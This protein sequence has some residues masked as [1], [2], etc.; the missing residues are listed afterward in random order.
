MPRRMPSCASGRQ[1]RLRVVL[2]HQR[3]VVEDVLAARSSISRMPSSTITASSQANAGIVGAAVGN[4]RGDQVA[5]AVLVLQAFAAER[6]AAGGGA[7]Q[8]AARSAGRPRPRSGRRRAGSRTSSS[9]CRT[10]AS[11]GRARCSASPPRSTT[12]SAPASVMPSSRIWPSL[13]FAVVEHRAA[14][15]RA[16]RAGRPASRCRSAGRGSPCR[17]C[18]PRRR[19][20][21]RCAG[22]ASGP[23]SRLPSRRTTAIVVD[24]SLPSAS[25][26][27]VRRRR[28]AA[29]TASAGRRCAAR[30]REPPSAARRSRR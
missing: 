23:C 26:A 6:R 19:R 28:R 3:H 12:T 18:A 9:R 22:R 2:V 7:E 1:R 25:S 5:G 21:A 10:A 15:P 13:R 24:I 14:R 4:G 20:S 30:G 29:G 27:N 16:R 11:A 8:E 17:R